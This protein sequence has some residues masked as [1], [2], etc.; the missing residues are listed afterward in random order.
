MAFKLGYCIQD[1]GRIPLGY[2]D[3]F[4]IFKEDIIKL[5][6]KLNR[7]PTT[8]EIKKELRV[9]S[10]TIAKHG[11]MQEIKNNTDPLF[12]WVDGIYLKNREDLIKASKILE[13]EKYNY[14]VKKIFS[15]ICK[16]KDL[17]TKILNN[18]SFYQSKTETEYKNLTKQN[19][20]FKTFSIPVKNK[21]KTQL[22]NY[23]MYE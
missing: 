4:E 22:I 23:L 7:F 17:Q 11:G 16:T 12:Y 14:S 20:E 8:L 5:I 15:F 21:L 19:S 1:L 9:G 18:I 2:Y 3:N 6:N 13:S 10:M